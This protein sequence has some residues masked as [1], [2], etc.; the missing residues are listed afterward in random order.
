MVQIARRAE[1]YGIDGLLIFYN[2]QNFDPWVIAATVLQHT[3]DVT[4]LVAL[5]PYALPPFTAAKLIHN[6]TVL[7]G[8][9]LDLNLITGA[10]KDELDQ[11]KDPLSHDERYQR[12]VEYATVVRGLLSSNK[13]FFHEGAFYQYRGSRHGR[14]CLPSTGRVFSWPVPPRPD[15][16]RRRKSPTSR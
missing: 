9:R 2:H 4:P 3:T 6:L 13:P 16:R 12:A 14:N 15:A 5:Q 11:V 1:T 7:H 8:R 10:A